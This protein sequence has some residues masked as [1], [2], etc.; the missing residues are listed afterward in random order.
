MI[1]K[2][3]LIELKT[4]VNPWKPPF[5]KTI[6]NVDVEVKAGQDFDSMEKVPGP[7]FKLIRCDSDSCIVQYSE[8]FTLKG[9]EHPGNKQVKVGK[10]PVSFTYL[11]GNDGITKKLSIKKIFGE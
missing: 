10:E 11:W 5:K 4:I 3:A 9:H 8:K 6:E 1:M 2:T 7:I